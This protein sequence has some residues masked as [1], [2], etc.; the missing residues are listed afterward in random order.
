LFQTSKD[1]TIDGSVVPSNDDTPALN[2]RGRT[3]TARSLGFHTSTCNAAQVL[4]SQLVASRFIPSGGAL[5][6]KH[7][8][9]KPQQSGELFSLQKLECSRSSLLH[10]EKKTKLSSPPRPATSRGSHGKSGRQLE[11]KHNDNR[12]DG[13][14]CDGLMFSESQKPWFVIPT[15]AWWQREGRSLEAR[16]PPA[17]MAHG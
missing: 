9:S 17:H 11:E 2:T 10:A 16:L 5:S 15:W 6:D 12:D 14:G 4:N 3:G 13:S 1:Q 8:K 7:Q